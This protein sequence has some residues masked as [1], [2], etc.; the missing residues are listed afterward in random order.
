MADLIQLSEEVAG[1]DKELRAFS[2]ALA[3][4]QKTEDRRQFLAH[5]VATVSHDYKQNWVLLLDITTYRSNIGTFH[6][7][8]LREEEA[9]EFLSDLENAFKAVSGQLGHFRKRLEKT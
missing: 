8:A 3:R 5:G 1:T 9:G 4:W 7:W 6:R 2:T